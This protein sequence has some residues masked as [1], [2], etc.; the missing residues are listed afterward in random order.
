MNIQDYSPPIKM[1]EKYSY[2]VY[3]TYRSSSW[4]W[5]TL[6]YAWNHFRQDPL[7]LEDMKANKHEFLSITEKAGDDLYPMMLGQF[8]DQIDTWA[9]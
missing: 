7:T 8:K 6:K 9:V 3:F 4:G 1:P 2:D 5:G